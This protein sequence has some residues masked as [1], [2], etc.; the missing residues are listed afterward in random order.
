[1]SIPHNEKRGERIT[2]HHYLISSPTLQRRRKDCTTTSRE[3]FP[4]IYPQFCYD[5]PS[6]LRIVLHMYIH[7]ICPWGLVIPTVSSTHFSFT[8]SH[9]LSF[10]Y[11]KGLCRVRIWRLGRGERQCYHHNKGG[12]RKKAF[13]PVSVSRYELSCPLAKENEK[14]KYKRVKK[15]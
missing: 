7:S 5:A 2:D 15:N 13:P 8:F 10:R 14:E 9:F 12:G 3:W 6:T 1:V 4:L 11:A